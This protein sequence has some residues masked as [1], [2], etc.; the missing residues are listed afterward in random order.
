V[1]VRKVGA[2]WVSSKRNILRKFMAILNPKEKSFRFKKIAIIAFCLLVFDAFIIGLPF[3][4]LLILFFLVVASG[5]SAIIFLFR[6]RQFSKL[7][8]IKALIY[9]TS[10]IGIIG[11]FK[12]NAYIGAENANVVINAINSY[13]ADT[14]MY[15]D[16]L[17]QLIPNYLDSIPNCAYRMID[18]KYRYYVDPDNADLMW[19]VMPPWG[20]RNYN[21]QNAEWTY[22]D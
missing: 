18:Y 14:G 2:R 11:I 21:F 17:T 12:F 19:T 15:P 16:N 5:I 8:A 22:L 9:F 4:G 13:Y 10:F 3:F 7:Y 1:Q 6:G 20:R